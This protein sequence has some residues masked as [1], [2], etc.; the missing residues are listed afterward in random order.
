[1]EFSTASHAQR[2]LSKGLISEFATA[3]P[4]YL[5]LEL[6]GSVFRVLGSA[7]MSD[8]ASEVRSWRLRL[9]D[10]GSGWRLSLT[11]C[12]LLAAALCPQAQGSVPIRG[13]QVPGSMCRC[14][15]LE[16]FQMSNLVP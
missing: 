14:G 5:L 13:C 7:G 6:V 9:R 10:N 16:P 1:M 3:Q 15:L 4:R 8:V 12:G 2:A 11:L